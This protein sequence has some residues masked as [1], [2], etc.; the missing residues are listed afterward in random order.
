M[1]ACVAVVFGATYVNNTKANPDLKFL[2]D[3]KFLRHE[4]EHI[5]SYMQE[6]YCDLCRYQFDRLPSPRGFCT[7]MCAQPQGFC[8][9]ENAWGAGQ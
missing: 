4:T 5:V 9:T 7:E 6:V 2:F 8:K 1:C 3:K